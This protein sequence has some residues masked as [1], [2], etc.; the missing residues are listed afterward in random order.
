M[1][2]FIHG[3]LGALLLSTI[4]S[5][6]LSC[7]GKP[8]TPDPESLAMMITSVTPESVVAGSEVTIEGVEFGTQ[9]ALVKVYF[10]DVEA[11]VRSITPTRII[12]VVPEDS[13][14]TCLQVIL[15]RR[16]T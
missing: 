7:D 4:A 10:G 1:I 5:L 12:V 14:G 3:S 2:R 6:L 16:W 11:E 9:P 13:T 8:L 15:H